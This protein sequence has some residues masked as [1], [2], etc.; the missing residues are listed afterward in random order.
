MYL[1]IYLLSIYIYHISITIICFSF[2]SSISPIYIYIY[3]FILSI[4]LDLS[5]L[6]IYYIS[7]IY[8]YIPSIHRLI[9]LSRLFIPSIHPSITYHFIYHSGIQ[10][11]RKQDQDYLF[12]IMVVPYYLKKNMISILKD[13]HYQLS[14]DVNLQMK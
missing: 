4:H 8:L 13:K 2:I 6:S 7:F 3:L 1:Q 5:H 10:E 14:Q 9:L 11:L 12:L